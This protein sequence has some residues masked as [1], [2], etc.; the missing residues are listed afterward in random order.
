MIVAFAA[1]VPAVLGAVF[2]YIVR[3]QIRTPSGD[4]IGAVV[5]RTHETGIASHLIL[6][7]LH[8]GQEAKE[9]E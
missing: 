6:R 8:N 4:R 7:E 3:R 5:E 1:T 9:E 2:S